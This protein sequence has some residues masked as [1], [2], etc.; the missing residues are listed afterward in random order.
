MR[1]AIL[2][3]LKAGKVAFEMPCILTNGYNVNLLI[4]VYMQDVIVRGQTGYESLCSLLAT[5]RAL[6]LLYGGAL[7]KTL[8][9]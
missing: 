8:P 9:S 7:H 5:T 1:S 6:L 4:Y 3:R 2:L